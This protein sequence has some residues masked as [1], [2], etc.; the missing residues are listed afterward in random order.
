MR[1]YISYS[2]CLSLCC[3]ALGIASA[4]SHLLLAATTSYHVGNSLTWDSRLPSLPIMAANEG[5]VHEVGYHITCGKPLNYIV[6]HP[7]ET[8][9]APTA[10]GTFGQALP[11]QEWDVVGLQPYTGF[12]STLATDLAA[13]EQLV[14]LTR[15]N[16]LN[17]D[18]SFFIFAAYPPQDVTVGG[19]LQ[20]DFS[21]KWLRDD[22]SGLTDAETPTQLS[23][24]YFNRLMSR[25][26]DLS[27]AI[28]QMHMIPVG[29]VIFELD[30]R[31]IA[32]EFAQFSDASKLYRDRYHL[33]NVGRY[34]AATTVY[35][36]IFGRDP[37]GIPVPAGQFVPNPDVSSDREITPDLSAAL[38]ATVWDI[39]SV[40]ADSGLVGVETVDQLC[41]AMGTAER[42]FDL[43]GNG[44]VG[45]EDLDELIL[46]RARTVYGDANLDG[47]L[48]AL[49]DGGV[50]LASLGG[51]T[52]K[53]WSDGDFDCSGDVTVSVDGAL[54]LESF[55]QTTSGDSAHPIAIPEPTLLWVIALLLALLTSRS[56]SRWRLLQDTFY[57]RHSAKRVVNVSGWPLVSPRFRGAAQATT[58]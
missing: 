4:G 57:A 22:L 3:I 54:L 23:R 37:A 38:R 36:T 10:S 30:R 55:G 6:N 18:T 17:D 56:G 26:R 35:A 25:L 58:R 42:R 39:V 7:D 46:G 21:A 15:Q 44:S 41:T 1:P 11:I 29:D 5:L 51:G 53:G 45:S 49:T 14:T 13:T 40:H 8:C 34:V 24:P 33:N 43:D 20:L 28:G 32:G 2:R 9:V 27:D 47:K 31:M 52:G 48:S 16:P 12:G 19:G 50:L